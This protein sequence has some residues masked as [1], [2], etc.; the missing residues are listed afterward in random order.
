LD[1]NILLCACAYWH[2][3]IIYVFAFFY[4]IS[5]KFYN[6]II[7][8]LVYLVNVSHS[9]N[10]YILY[11]STSLFLLLKYKEDEDK[12]I[13]RPIIYCVLNALPVLVFN[14]SCVV[15]SN[16]DGGIM[17]LFATDMVNICLIF[18]SILLFAIL[19][20]K[21]EGSDVDGWL[22]L[23]DTLYYIIGVVA[24]IA[25]VYFELVAWWSGILML[26]YWLIHLI[27]LSNNE[28]IRD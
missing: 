16:S 2:L 18:G 11:L 7:E 14:I 4:Y 6:C 15:E 26:V 20:K 10:H 24:F 9:Y 17:L 12:E 23:R 22:L 28:Y 5:I 27:I 3:G 8:D 13:Y 21:K 25:L 19:P 1:N